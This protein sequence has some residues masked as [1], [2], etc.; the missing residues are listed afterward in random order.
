M[1]KTCLLTTACFMTLVAGPV[2][3][4]TSQAVQQ[5]SKKLASAQTPAL[6]P[7]EREAQKHYRIAQEA[8]KN[9]DLSIAA[10]ELDQ[11]AQL[12]PKNAIIWYNLAQ[13]ESKKGDSASA[14]QHLQ[15]AE[16][17]GLPKSV[18]DNAAQLDAKLSY[19]AKS[20]ADSRLDGPRTPVPT[21]VPTPCEIQQ[22][23]RSVEVGH[24]GEWGDLKFLVKAVPNIGATPW[25]GPSIISVKA[26]GLPKR[27]ITIA[28][29]SS[30]DLQVCGQSVTITFEG[31]YSGAFLWNFSSTKF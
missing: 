3:A 28:Q 5:G 26:P 9:N 13:V 20:V 19:E 21:G 11:A 24:T 22:G 14:L 1:S 27:D 23:K 18:Q 17:L 29:A 10:D 12:A 25:Q 16:S 31:S 7:E 30:V 4:Q 6:T 8:L 15:K 2:L